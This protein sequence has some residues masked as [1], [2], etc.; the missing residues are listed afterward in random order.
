MSFVNALSTD[1]KVVN[2]GAA[3]GNLATTGSEHASEYN[4][5]P[6]VGPGK[7][8]GGAHKSGISTVPAAKSAAAPAAAVPLAARVMPTN[9]CKRC[10]KTIYAAERPVKIGGMMFHPNCFTCKKTGVKLTLRTATVSKDENGQ[11]EV[12]IGN[13]EAKSSLGA[14]SHGKE[15]ELAPTPVTDD[16]ITVRVGEVPDANMRTSDRKFGIAGKAAFRGGADVEANQDQG[17]NYGDGSVGVVNQTVVDRP[18]TTV[19]NINLSEKRWNG[20]TGD[21]DGKYRGRGKADGQ[22][23]TDQEPDTGSA[24]GN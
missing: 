18:P 8:H 16:A 19:N 21:R 10:Y 9:G 22:H 5:L 23:A 1:S 2:T 11:N 14:Y 17:S 3:H 12:Y 7:S 20:A 13:S 4:N 24:Y 15:P 6:T